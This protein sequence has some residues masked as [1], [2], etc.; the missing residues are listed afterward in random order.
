MTVFILILLAKA[1]F[2]LAA[3]M[4]TLLFVR[5]GGWLKGKIQ[6]RTRRELERAL[7]RLAPDFHPDKSFIPEGIG[8]AADFTTARLFIAE[9]D[10]AKTQ[11]TILPFTALRGISTGEINQNG[12]Q[13]VYVDIN[14]NTPTHP[15][16]R[17]LFGENA[18]LAGE[19]TEALGRLQAA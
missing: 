8:L 18:A 3:S 17:L 19:V 15:R 1:A 11:A 7:S 12:F 13:D 9:Q 16:W 14:V 5:G 10:G 6:T 4:P 2:C